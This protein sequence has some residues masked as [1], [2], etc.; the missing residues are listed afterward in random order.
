ML[1]MD[2]QVASTAAL[3]T[4]VSSETLGI[5]PTASLLAGAGALYGVLH[6]YNNY[7]NN[8]AKTVNTKQQIYTIKIRPDQTLP[9]QQITILL[10]TQTMKQSMQRLCQTTCR[11]INIS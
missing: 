11:T 6:E 4:L 7:L 1:K 9:K 8:A 5:G 10:P 2:N 3:A